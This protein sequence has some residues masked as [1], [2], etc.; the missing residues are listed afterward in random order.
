MYVAC[1]W[2][3]T[4]SFQLLIRCCVLLSRAFAT[5]L[6]AVPMLILAVAEFGANTVFVS[7]QSQTLMTQANEFAD[8]CNASFVTTCTN[9]E[10][11]CTYHLHLHT[12]HM[13]R[14]IWLKILLFIG[15]VVSV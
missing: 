1:L 13:T 15:V 12:I 4:L 7:E 10:Q 8:S 5:R 14:V 2:I 3:T 9:F 11:H 6:P